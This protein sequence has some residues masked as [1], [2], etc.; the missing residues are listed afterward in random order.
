MR[1][2]SKFLFVFL[3]VVFTFLFSNFLY[4]SGYTNTFLINAKKMYGSLANIPRNVKD[5][6]IIVSISNSSGGKLTNDDVVIFIEVKDKEEVSKLYYSFNKKDWY[7]DFNIVTYGKKA[8]AKLILK[9]SISSYIYVYAKN[10]KENTS[11]IFKTKVFIDKTNPKLTYSIS[12]INQI[13]S[14]FLVSKDNVEMKKIQYS[15]NGINWYE[16][17]KYKYYSKNKRL[18]G[19]L[20]VKTNQKVYIRAIDKVGNISNVE[21]IN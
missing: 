17:V 21:I 10:K 4:K 6:P 13:K 8:E 18:D 11:Y 15:Y 5:Y 12:Y 2:A 19:K 20:E 9:D 14:I 1:K 3:V 16:N 7:S